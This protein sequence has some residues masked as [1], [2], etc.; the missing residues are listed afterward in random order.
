MD[1]IVE[2]L[3]DIVKIAIALGV[4][5]VVLAVVFAVRSSG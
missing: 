4:V 1:R 3:I 5:F 2:Q